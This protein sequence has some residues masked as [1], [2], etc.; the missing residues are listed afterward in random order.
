MIT[1]IIKCERIRN[2]F[3]DDYL[4]QVVIAEN[5]SLSLRT[6]SYSLILA[7]LDRFNHLSDAPVED[8][9]HDSFLINGKGRFDDNN[10]PLTIHHVQRNGEYIFRFINTGFDNVLEVCTTAFQK[11]LSHPTCG[12]GGLGSFPCQGHTSVL[13]IETHRCP[14]KG[15]AITGVG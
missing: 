13:K 7:N 4:N 15:S 1:I 3:G 5:S 10:T 11:V 8:L 6:S 9:P 14:A 2:G 12:L